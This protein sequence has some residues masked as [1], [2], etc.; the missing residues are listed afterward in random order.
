MI[1]VF[2]LLKVTKLVESNKATLSQTILTA[3]C[4]LG[5]VVDGDVGLVG[6]G[7][8]ADVVLDPA[9][10]NL[11]LLGIDPRQVGVVGLQGA[12]SINN[13]NPLRLLCCIFTLLWAFI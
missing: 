2:A 6:D 4:S 5:E 11:P 1:L 8:L 10:R 9:V 3:F 13:L 7:V 12:N